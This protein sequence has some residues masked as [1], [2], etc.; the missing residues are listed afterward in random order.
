MV[1]LPRDWF[2][3]EEDAGATC[4]TRDSVVALLEGRRSLSTHTETND[5]AVIPRKY[6][7]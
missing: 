5:I 3:T 7:S 2:D 4:T 1:E 6:F